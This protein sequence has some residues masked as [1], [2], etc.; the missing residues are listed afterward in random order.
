MTSSIPY[1]ALVGGLTAGVCD[2]YLLGNKN[3][4]TA[5]MFGTAVGASIY[6]APY[7]ATIVPPLSSLATIPFGTDNGKSLELALIELGAGVGLTL[8]LDKFVL[9]R[10]SGNMLK[11]VGVVVLSDFVG[12]Y[13]NDYMTKQPLNYISGMI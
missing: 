3:I 11:K 6:V 12:E 10:A 2:Y 5:G 4:N 9:K 1:N 7:I 13:A 8:V